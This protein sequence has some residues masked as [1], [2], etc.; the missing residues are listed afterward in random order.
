MFKITY[1]IPNVKMILANSRVDPQVLNGR[2][3]A[4]AE[5]VY[6]VIKVDRDLP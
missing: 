2:R 4:G 5:E 1:G 3:R 6:Y